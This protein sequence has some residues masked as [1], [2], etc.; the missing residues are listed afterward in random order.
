M[1]WSWRHL[2]AAQDLPYVS[3]RNDPGTFYRPYASQINCTGRSSMHKSPI[4]PHRWP[5]HILNAV[6]AK[7]PTQLTEE[8]CS[9]IFYGQ[10]LSHSSQMYRPGQC[11]MQNSPNAHHRLT[12]EANLWTPSTQRTG[13]LSRTPITFDRRTAVMHRPH[14]SLSHNYFIYQFIYQ[15]TTKKEQGPFN[16]SPR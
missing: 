6:D 1:A 7:F 11:L 15:M 2:L 16:I 4:K 3:R 13:K 12:V 14:P 5:I 9:T 8:T 10:I